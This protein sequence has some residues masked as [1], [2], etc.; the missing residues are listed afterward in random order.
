MLL[1]NVDQETF[2]NAG[3]FQ[4]SELACSTQQECNL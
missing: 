1:L 2:M 3:M 4:G